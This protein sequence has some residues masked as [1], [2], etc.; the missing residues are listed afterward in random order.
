M[1]LLMSCQRLVATRVG[2]MEAKQRITKSLI[3]ALAAKEG[4][5]SIIWDTDVTGFGVRLGKKTPVYILGYRA[6]GKPYARVS[7]GRADR[8][9]VDQAR[10]KAKQMIGEA[11]SGIDPQAEKKAKLK[12]AKATAAAER[13]QGRARLTTV[14]EQYLGWLESRNLSAAHIRA[15]RLYT[16]GKMVPAWGNRSISTITKDDAR[17]LLASVPKDRG[18]VAH[19]IYRYGR[20]LWDWALKEDLV[21]MNLWSA[22]HTPAGPKPR[23]NRLKTVG[24]I[25]LFWEATEVTGQPWQSMCRMLL[26]TG[27]RRNEIA[28]MRWS[29]L[30][31][32]DGLLRIN[33]NERGTK[34]RHDYFIPLVDE[35]IEMLD[36]IAGGSSWPTDGYVFT[37]TGRSAASGFSKAGKRLLGQMKER[38][39]ARHFTLHDLR[40][41]HATG[42]EQLRIR[43][44]IGLLTQNKTSTFKNL[45]MSYLWYAYETEI[46][47]AQEQWRDYVLECLK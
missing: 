43:P 21:E 2:S 19:S 33:A 34:T 31:R 20:A 44:D 36:D 11:A 24:E 9:T 6:P 14:V 45:A 30:N 37:T 32:G 40:R 42:L 10:N 17:D 4:D 41:T 26:L 12:A 15:A 22:I 1:G 5:G 28:E 29:E 47:E 8:V 39:Y 35:I 25:K 18:S 38:G 3:T 23:Q 16:E 7:I 27:A 46:R 13:K